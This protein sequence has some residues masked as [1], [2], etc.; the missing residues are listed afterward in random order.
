MSTRHPHGHDR[1]RKPR[2]V[3][4]LN[5]VEPHEFQRPIAR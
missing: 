4:A 3:F 2:F 1:N 5:R